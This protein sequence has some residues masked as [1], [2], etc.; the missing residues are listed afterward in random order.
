MP[1]YKKANLV[2]YL[3][4]LPFMLTFLIFFLFPLLYSLVLSFFEYHGYGEAKW[5]G[6]ENYT[7]LFQYGAF[8]QSVGNTLF[9]YVLYVI[10]L[11]VVAFL[12]A[13]L[14]SEKIMDRFRNI[15]KPLIF[16]P[17]IIPVVASSLIFKI[18]FSTRSGAI[19]QMLGTQVPFLENPQYMRWIVLILM[20]WRG[21]GW[22]MVIYSAGLTSVSSEVREAAR[23]DGANYFQQVIY[24]IVPMMKPIFLFAFITN[25]I[26]TFKLYTEPTVLLEQAGGV[27]DRSATPIM[28][29]LVQNISSGDFGTA[30]AVGWFIF[31]VIILITLVQFKLINGKGE[32]DI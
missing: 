19:N 31:V 8:W 11:M 25:S 30:S 29:L 18:L 21:I 28:Y 7:T 23:I 13:L 4:I 10:P 22:Y 27:I 17:Q 20:I 16:L 9:Y 12:L 24:V 6:I 5:V 15:Y 1:K 2:P 14:M 32:Q 26:N 3:F